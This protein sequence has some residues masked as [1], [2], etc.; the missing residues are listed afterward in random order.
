MHGSEVT[1]AE[2]RNRTLFFGGGG[3]EGGLEKEQQKY[4]N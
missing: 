2:T 4:G 3:G 1:R